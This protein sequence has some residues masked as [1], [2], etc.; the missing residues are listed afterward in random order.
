[1]IV[2]ADDPLAEAARAKG[3]RIIKAERPRSDAIAQLGWR[4]ILSGVTISPEA[5]EANY[6]G[7]SDTDLFVK[8]S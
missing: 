6:I 7:R 5:L 8:G 3:L 4:K 2:T 1:M